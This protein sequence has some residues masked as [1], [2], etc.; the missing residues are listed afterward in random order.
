MLNETAP[1]ADAA[2][3]HKK[4][5]LIVGGS[6]GAGIVA[7]GIAVAV[8]FGGGASPA[9]TA[10]GSTSSSPS[11]SAPASGSPSTASPSPASTQAFAPFDRV[12]Y[13]QTGPLAG[14]ITPVA[15]TT[16]TIAGNSADATLPEGLTGLS[17]DTDSMVDSDLDPDN[18]NL[19]EVL[20]NTNKPVIRFGGQ[21]VD[22]R[23]FWT[24]TNEPLPKWTI[25]PGYE[26][27][28]RPI[29]KVQPVDLERIKRLLDAS[30]GRVVLSVD[31]GHFDPARAADF[32]AHAQAIFGDRLLGVALGNEPNG[33][34]RTY[35]PY[36]GLR[37]SS[38]SFDDWAKE[39]TSTA[40]AIVKAAPAVKIIGPEVYSNEWWK[41]F[42][43]LKLPNV[44]ALAY[45]HYPLP[46]CPAASDP[47][48][49]SIARAMSRALADSSAAYH[50]T[51]AE[52]AR[53][54]NIP[55][56]L[57][58]TGISS[59][60]GSN[61][62]TNAHV[63]AL[64]TVNYALSAARAGVTQVDLHS[65]LEACKG[66]PPLSPICDTGGYKKPNGVLAMRPAY[67]GMMLV[68][69]IGT[70][71]FQQ[72]DTSGNENI[73]AY[74]VKHDDGSMSVVVVNQNDPSTTAQA[75]V[76]V[77]LPAAAGT[78]TMSQMTGPTFDAQGQTRIDG[79]ESAGVPKDQQ[80]RIPGF[81][82]G[83]QRVSVPLTSGTATVLNFTF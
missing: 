42:A 73:Y 26:G 47:L 9:S 53:S 4:R 69:N 75:P 16:I 68:N 31:M 54:A 78:G 66:G 23:Y 6:L 29:V 38:W 44:G 27:D 79:L 35:N 24:S 1:T 34:G 32:A 15:E 50:Q 64:W 62:T 11:S 13:Q 30:D 60:G 74:A 46:N 83:D 57:T 2:A 3:A 10:T 7:A 61:E 8:A 70:G 33:Y 52:V 45:H 81:A 19:A 49:P 65:S 18:S 55:A 5:S 20:R 58:E 59:C 56:W 17:I 71:S 76:T 43:D 67:Y 51:A 28:K 22:R 14:A 40:Q 48:A 80:G 39:A 72:L 82:A 63:S 36:W 25:V 41:Q 21:S 77:Q 37:D 12:E